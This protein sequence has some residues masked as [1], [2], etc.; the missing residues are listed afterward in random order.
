MMEVGQHNNTPNISMADLY[1]LT[2]LFYLPYEHGK[3]GNSFLSEFKWLNE[4]CQQAN[5][6]AQL[7]KD[8]V[9]ACYWLILLHDSLAVRP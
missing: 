8:K 4:N 3:S 9:S 7:F 6:D 2:D 1:L 5:G